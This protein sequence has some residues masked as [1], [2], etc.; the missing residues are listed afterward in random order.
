[1]DDG[2]A[3]KQHLLTHLRQE[4]AAW[5]ALLHEVGEDRMTQ[6]RSLGDWSFKDTVAHLTA[7]AQYAEIQKLE[8]AR[9]GESMSTV[10][11]TADAD[12]ELINRWIYCTH[13]YEPLQAVLH[14]SRALWDRLEELIQALP[15]P[16]L[17]E[18]GRFPW[19]QG[20]AL[21]TVVNDLTGHFHEEHESLI[22]AWLAAGAAR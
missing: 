8:A 3:T 10:A 6:A 13:R 14:Q 4:R 1:M 18:P 17:T 7:W 11:A 12:V 20:R 21:G 15:E 2:L 19:M 9:R 16:D 5:E 22:R